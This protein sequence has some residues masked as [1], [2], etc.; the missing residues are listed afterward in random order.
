MNF[1]SLNVS[2]LLENWKHVDLKRKHSTI[3]SIA[4][5]EDVTVE[6]LSAKLSTFEVTDHI[7]VVKVA[8]NVLSVK[9]MSHFLGLKCICIKIYRL[10]RNR[11]NNL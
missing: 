8:F 11:R 1:T 3:G 6:S 4:L 10:D 7:T 2:T 5:Q 9:R